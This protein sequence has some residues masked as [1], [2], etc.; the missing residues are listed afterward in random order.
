MA[1]TMKNA[2]VHKFGSLLSIEERKLCHDWLLCLMSG[3]PEKR[4][5]KDAVRAEAME[6]FKISKSE[7]ERA[8]TTAIAETRNYHWSKPN[9]RASSRRNGGNES[10]D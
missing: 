9:W 4:R 1:K 2:V 5:T 10:A 7:F 8:W 3:S 6:H